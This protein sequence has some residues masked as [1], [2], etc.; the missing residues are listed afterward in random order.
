[1]IRCYN[2][3]SIF[4]S[5][6]GLFGVAFA[7][8]YF[9]S[10]LKCL[11][12]YSLAALI[13]A[14]GVYD[15]ITP[16]FKNA[17]ASV[18]PEFESDRDFVRKVEQNSPANGMILQ[19]P[20]MPFPE[21]LPIVRMEDYSHFRGPL[22][23]D[24]L[25]WSYGATKGRSESDKIRVVSELPLNWQQIK[26]MGYTGIYIDR[27]GFTDQAAAL[28]KELKTKLHEE[29]LISPNGRLVFFALPVQ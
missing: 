16:E 28:E 22:H 26:A 9:Q 13:L 6:F 19:L 5:L 14:V 15:Q 4:L 17:N 29:A 7:V 3:I 25:R 11:W 18:R 27:F 23:S 24:W 2:R 10:R 1:M 21:S 12:T 8:R 20:F